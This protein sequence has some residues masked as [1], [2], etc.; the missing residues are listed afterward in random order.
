MKPVRGINGQIYFIEKEIHTQL[1]YLVEVQVRFDQKYEEWRH[2]RRRVC[3][4]QNDVHVLQLVRDQQQ[5]EDFNYS[6]NGNLD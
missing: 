1:S 2:E 3:K 6:L 5:H 4:I